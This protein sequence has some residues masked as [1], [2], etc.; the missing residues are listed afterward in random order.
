MKLL[1]ASVF[2]LLSL[3]V[4]PVGGFVVLAPSEVYGQ[5]H[6]DEHHA[7]SHGE[8]HGH[9]AHIGGPEEEPA[10]FDPKNW[11]T[12]L[13]V[14]SLIVFILLLAVLTKFAWNP[15]MTALDEREAS[16]RKNIEDAETARVRS[17]QLLA[18]RA[19]K[20]DLV[21]DEVREILAEARRDAEHTKAEI[22]AS[23]QKEAEA[24]K[25]R[26]VDEI[27]R[28]RD[29]ALND[30]FGSMSSQVTQATEHVIGRTLSDED[31]GRL[32]NESLAELSAKG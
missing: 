14:Y 32:I 16:I 4:L 29:Q 3:F 8:D 1:S 20:L 28:A 19:Q 13:S 30:L 10:I 22:M 18:E 7:E 5:E 2:L 24:T 15:V 27:D 6:A 12:D 11:R 21:Q 9:H 25:R 31:R 17:E 26:A 23:A